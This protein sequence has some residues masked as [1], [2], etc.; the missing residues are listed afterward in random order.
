MEYVLVELRVPHWPVLYVNQRHAAIIE[1]LAVN[2]GRTVVWD[3]VW[4]NGVCV[5]L[6][7]TIKEKR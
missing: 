1:Q 7:C 2:E 6:I 4:C 5:S 3:E